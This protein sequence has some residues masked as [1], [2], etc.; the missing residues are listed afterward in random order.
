MNTEEEIKTC[1]L[2]NAGK[3]ECK[4]PRVK[5]TLFCEFHQSSMSRLWLPKVAT[6]EELEFMMQRD[7]E[8]Q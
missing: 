2:R 6:P 5:G 8:R 7:G 1:A 3:G 4:R